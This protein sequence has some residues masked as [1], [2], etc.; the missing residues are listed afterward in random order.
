MSWHAMAPDIYDA[1]SVVPAAGLGTSSAVSMWA[2]AAPA[3]GPASATPHRL[4]HVPR[5]LLQRMSETAWSAGRSEE[6]IWIEA[7][8]EWLSRRARGDDPPPTAPAAALPP[9]PRAEHSW[10]AIDSLLAQLRDSRM[11]AA[12]A[13]HPRPGAPAA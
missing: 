13:A 9:R 4:L 10:H 12:P 1:P 8:R 3:S 7:A 6:D 2:W 11:P 5:E